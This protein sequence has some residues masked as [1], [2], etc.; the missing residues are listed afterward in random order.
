MVIRRGM[1]LALTGVAVGLAGAFVV[2]RVL[3]SLL[4]G[5]SSADSLI[6]AEVSL[7]L[8]LVALAAGYIPARRAAR[9]DP[10]VALRYE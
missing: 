6:Y 9:V 3:A 2:S 8:V 4:F 1:R 5:I 7:P 10:T